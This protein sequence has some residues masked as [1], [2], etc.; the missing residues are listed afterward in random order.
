GRNAELERIASRDDRTQNAVEIS[1]AA[2]RNIELQNLHLAHVATGV[3]IRDQAQDVTIGGIGD[4]V[5]GVIEATGNG[6]TSRAMLLE[7]VSDIVLRNLDV[8]NNSGT[9]IR[10]ESVA[11]VT[12]E[13]S[14]LYDN[15]PTARAPTAQAGIRME[16]ATRVSIFGND[17]QGNPHGM[18][19]INVTDNQVAQ[20]TIADN[21]F[22]G[23]VVRGERNDLRQNRITANGGD[24]ISG[25]VG[26]RFRATITFAN[27][28]SQSII[29]GDARDP[30]RVLA[31]PESIVDVFEDLDGEGNTYIGSA[32][33]YDGR[34]EV[35]S[36]VLFA[37]P[38]KL[39][40]LVT[41][42]EG[43][44]SPFERPN[45]QAVCTMSCEQFVY[46][47]QEDDRTQ[48]KL[49][50]G[51][52]NVTLYTG[53]SGEQVT[54]P[55]IAPNGTHVVFVSDQSGTPQ[56]WLTDGSSS[57]ALPLEGVAVA[58]PAWSPDGR[59]LVFVG[60]RDGQRDL[61]TVAIDL[62][63]R[64]LGEPVQL[65]NDAAIEADP[66]WSP[67]GALLAFTSDAEG[68]AS[69][70]TSRP[71]G[72]EPVRRTTGG[73]ASSPAWSPEG[74]SLVYVQGVPTGGQ[75]LRQL[76]LADGTDEAL[77]DGSTADRAPTWTLDGERLLFVSDRDGEARFYSFDVT[78]QT[79]R[80]LSLL[81]LGRP[82]APDAGLPF[83]GT[84]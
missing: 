58:D 52:T 45:I 22:G 84:L 68:T 36:T 37:N 38:A 34:F 50:R 56:L 20:N 4:A 15:G 40:A 65:T 31:P 59:Q 53:T 57:T 27:R 77:T 72:T 26:H 83:P 55:H 39:T 2:T 61:Y 43:A 54:T 47:S 28:G 10:M 23:I 18:Y 13:N 67:D 17:I 14:R 21:R 80:S 74:T 5:V 76:V 24:G 69:L 25:V 44:T 7:N 81:L 73:A 8:R 12:L 42:P 62:E 66:H 48:L 79:V 70:Y 32:R 11:D 9:G 60:E 75:Q 82:D 6:F 1:G 41:T 49:A 64:T 63:A 71:D 29:R 78:T 33:V 16:E 35:V 46:V 19:M 3:Y 51:R 30:F